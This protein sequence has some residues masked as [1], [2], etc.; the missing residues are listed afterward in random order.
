MKKLILNDLCIEILQKCPNKC[1]YC[2]SNSDLT[3]E[4]II[5]F[6][7][8]KNTIS[9]LSRK[10]DINEI[11]LSGGEPLLHKDIYK[12]V[13]FCAK[14]AL[15]TTI[16]TSGVLFDEKFHEIYKENYKLLE[17]AGLNKIVFDLQTVN[18]EIYDKL[19]G[20]EGNLQFAKSSIQNAE[21][22]TF[23]KSIHFIPNKLN[24]LQ[25]DKVLE[26]AEK[27]GVNELRVLRFV[28]QGR[29]RENVEQL[30]L[31]EEELRKFIKNIEKIKP[32][33][34]KIRVGI[35]LLENSSHICTA[36]NDKLHIRFDGQILPCPAFK[37]INVED[38]ENFKSINIYNNLDEL[39][40]KNDINSTRLCQQYKRHTY[41]KGE[42]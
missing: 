40:I 11:S 22:F 2:S 35:P 18:E 9:F 30:L 26:F 33:T 3:K 37:D 21:K 31:N 28:P 13:E 8:L 7:T 16:Y 41:Q 39:E 5:D 15:K 29:G 17:K 19:M 10:C 20:T 34:T 25:F 23:E 6:E 32:K 42:N 24:Y 38:I 1:I 14:N 27:S 12:I 4:T 36:G